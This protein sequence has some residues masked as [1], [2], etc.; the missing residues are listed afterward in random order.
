[1]I[2]LSPRARARR[3]FGT[4]IGLLMVLAII[5]LLVDTGYMQKDEEGKTRAASYIEKGKDTACIA[6]LRTLKGR[7]DQAAMSNNGQIP[8]SNVLRARLG[9]VRCPG[10]GTYQV[11]PKDGQV[12][13]T[14]HAPV[15]E[16]RIASVISLN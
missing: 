14:E 4:L 6:D 10:G 1:M 5:F 2:R 15:P 8:P 9:S 13:C 12:Y 16:H 11:D 7:I 3:G